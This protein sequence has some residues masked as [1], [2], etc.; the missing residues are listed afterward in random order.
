[1]Y[2]PECGYEIS[3]FET[4]CPRCENARRKA[5]V[6][7]VERPASSASP[8][9]TVIS[10]NTALCLALIVA[11]GGGI[12]LGRFWATREQAS[13]RMAPTVPTLVDARPLDSAS[14]QTPAELAATPPPT[15][16]SARP[17][18]AYPK[19]RPG[20]A[21]HG[22]PSVGSSGSNNRTPSIL[23][24]AVVQRMPV[25]VSTP[26]VWPKAVSTADD[27]TEQRLRAD[28]VRYN[29]LADFHQT[30]A[31]NL[32][33][34]GYGSEGA[35][36][37]FSAAMG[38]LGQRDQAEF[39]LGQCLLRKGDAPGATA[40]FQLVVASQGEYTDLSKRAAEA[41]KQLGQW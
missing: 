27:D 7:P 26:R 20:G 32:L 37:A 4:T 11:V 6:P 18:Q 28:I 25:P 1:M 2:C 19:R 10:R 24:P 12:V 15:A 21:E 41:L 36:P 8:I 13:E 5:V 33:A 23:T 16:R 3:P 31:N 39:D 29:Q 34:Q 35:S 22:P 17:V 9:H 40:C 30:R 14:S 38:Y